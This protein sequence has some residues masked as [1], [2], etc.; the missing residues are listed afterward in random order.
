MSN[1]F[2]L[3]KLGIEAKKVDIPAG[4]EYVQSSTVALAK[5]LLM[6]Y[7]DVFKMQLKV[8][9]KLKIA[10]CYNNKVTKDILKQYDYKSYKIKN[11]R[12][13]VAQFIN[14]NKAGE[15]ILTTKSN[16]TV[17]IMSGI[18]Y[19]KD[20]DCDLDAL[21]SSVIKYVYY[22][23]S[24]LGMKPVIINNKFNNFITDFLGI[25]TEIQE[26]K[27]TKDIKSM[28]NRDCSTRTICNL[29]NYNYFDVIDMQLEGSK[30]YHQIHSNFLFVIQD[31]LNSDGYTDLKIDKDMTVA[32]FCYMNKH[33]SYAISSCNHIFAYI[34]GSIIDNKYCLFN[35]DQILTQKIHVVLGKEDN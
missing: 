2:L 32:E 26:I 28:R 6:E 27:Y 34:N 19:Y 11:S 10:S 18:I 16:Y 1:K 9:Y 13:N 3:K 29:L 4:C 35:V 15:F 21:L 14:V 5:F 20:G 31:I 12:M 7:D 23:P 33:H 30:K 8:A 25:G 22:D 17:R 24:V